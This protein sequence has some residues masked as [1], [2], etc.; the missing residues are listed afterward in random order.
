MAYQSLL[1]PAVAQLVEG[2]WSGR[3]AIAEGRDHRF[4]LRWQG[5]PAPLEVLSCEV[6][7]PAF[8]EVQ[9]SF[10]IPAYQLVYWLMQRQGDELPLSF[11]RWLFTGEL[12]GAT[13]NSGA[14]GS[15]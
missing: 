15:A 4:T 6:R 12:P 9:Y 3:R 1:G 5:E 14:E 13:A 8:P 7:F 10:A 2:E 11:W